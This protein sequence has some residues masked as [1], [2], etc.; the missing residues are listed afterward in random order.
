M[1]DSSG[2]DAM[3]NEN[4]KETPT[5][6]GAR[7]VW[8][9][10]ALRA[11]DLVAFNHHLAALASSGLPLE[12]GL[13]LA[14]T[15]ARS[16]RVRR[17]IEGVA[18]DLEKGMPL[19]EAFDRQRGAFPLA[20]ARMMVGV[21]GTNNLPGLL[22][23]LGKHQELAARMRAL[24]G[25]ALAYPMV[26]F[27][28]VLVV[29]GLMG[30][31]VLPTMTATYTMMAAQSVK[32]A[33]AW[34]FR[35]GAPQ[36]SGELPLPTQLVIAI[37]PYLPAVVITLMAIMV[38]VPVA[39]FVLRMLRMDGVAAD[40]VGLRLP[41]V[42]Q[43][44]RHSALARFLDSLTVS[45]MAGV[46]LPRGLRLSAAVLGY[47]RITADADK[48]AAALEAGRPA[49]SVGAMRL[50]PESLPDAI[51]ASSDTATLGVTLEALAVLHRQQAELR[52][53]RIPLILVPLAVLAVGLLVAVLLAAVLTPLGSMLRLIQAVSGS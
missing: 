22:L 37:G 38:L 39:A 40:V 42:G 17:A 18:A 25:K 31:Y 24:V 33:Q 19:H 35:S 6:I 36:Y 41:V 9:F 26:V 43:A 13:R 44:M 20:Y 23:S 15:E 2:G 14:A 47:P 11:E 16:A 51:S 1:T 5:S 3:R 53:Q 50:L 29:A 21:A 46:D 10:S 27:A 12:A 45:T 34:R 4:A 8:P 30:S 7:M 48:L 49:N 52:A 28:G 32:M